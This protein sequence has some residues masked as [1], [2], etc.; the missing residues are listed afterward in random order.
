MFKKVNQLSTTLEQSENCREFSERLL[1]YIAVLGAF[2]VVEGI[3][4]LSCGNVH[5]INDFINFLIMMTALV[6]SFRC[7]KLSQNP[8]DDHYNYGYRRLNL[9][10]TFINTVFLIFAFIFNLVD[11]FHHLAE[12]LSKDDSLT[13]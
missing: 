11:N 10:A 7:I 6:I 3:I 8:S 2:A 13:S 12:D 1:I 9:L 4:G 5:I